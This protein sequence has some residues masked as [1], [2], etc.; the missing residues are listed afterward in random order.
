MKKHQTPNEFSRSQTGDRVSTEACLTQGLTMN[1]YGKGA[2]QA[3]EGS[4]R[5][6]FLAASSPAVR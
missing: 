5:A 1:A 2:I 6:V 4:E 3:G